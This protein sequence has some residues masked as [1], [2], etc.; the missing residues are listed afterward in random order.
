MKFKIDTIQKK[1]GLLI[2]GIGTM[3]IMLDIIDH[4]YNG[5]TLV[6]ALLSTNIWIDSILFIPGY[7]SLLT[8]SKVLKILQVLSFTLAGIA[9]VLTAYNEVYGP[10]LFFMGWLLA[11]QYGYFDLHKKIKYGFLIGFFVVIAQISAYLNEKPVFI[12]HNR[13]L[14]FS[15]FMVFFVMIVWEDI[16]E[17]DEKLFRENKHLQSDYRAIQAEIESIRRERK[18]FNLKEA[19]I[20]PAEE[21]VLRVLVR[22]KASN[23]EI[24]ER[25]N[26]SES[27]VK[28]H[29]YNIF[30]KL[31]VD[32]RFTVI[33]LCQYN[34]TIN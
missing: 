8:E 26:I 10:S 32:N 30:N 5:E 20:S 2:S 21:R 18:P 12:L 31:G 19:R 4:L 3:I 22:Y 9:N 33:D 6:Q 13:L 29:L 1:V 15:L 16:F 25:L 14:L 24:A 17:R 34:F 28:L 11:R 7:L 23:R 27:T